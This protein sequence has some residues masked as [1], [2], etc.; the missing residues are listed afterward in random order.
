MKADR[1]NFI[2]SIQKLDADGLKSLCLSLYD[3]VGAIEAA[4]AENKRI[5][6][7]VH[8]QYAELKEK[9]DKLSKEKKELEILLQKEV[10][11][12]A[13]R[14]KS[15]FGRKTES[16][17]ALFSD[18]M[19]TEEFVDES[20]VEDLGGAG[21]HHEGHG[22]LV[23]PHKGGS[24]TK[25]NSLRQA[26]D[27]LPKKYVYDLDVD[28]YNE[29]YGEGNW[30]VDL[31]HEHILIRKIMACY[32]E[33]RIY[34][35]VVAVGRERTLCTECYENPLIDKS[36]VSDGLLSEVLTNKFHMGLPV[37]RQTEYYAMQGLPI[38][39]QTMLNWINTAVPKYLS[40][41]YDYMTKM[42][43]TFK[44]Q[45]CDETYIRVNK[46]GYRPG[47]KSIMWIQTNSQFMD[48]P[49]II[50]FSYEANRSTD[51]LRR[52]YK[53]F[54]GYLTCDAYVSYKTLEEERGGEIITT[55]CLMHLRRYFAEA[56]F[57]NDVDSM[58]DAAVMEMPETKV[59]LIIRDIYAR[60]N[61]L[62]ELDA[63]ERLTKRQETVLPLMDNLYAYIHE[64]GD[65]TDGLSY[66][67][68]KAVTY[69]INQEEHVRRFLKDGNIPCD[70]GNVERI[71]RS[72][73]VGRANWMFADTVKGADVYAI[74]YS[75]VLTA[76]AN[77]ANVQK[78]LKYL[79]EKLPPKRGVVDEQF[80]ATMMP[81]SEE[82]RKYEFDTAMA[83]LELSE[84]LFPP[85][86]KPRVSMVRRANADSAS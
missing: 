84:R 74:M 27:R 23:P 71:I 6:T 48:E 5:Y 9:Y 29:L 56:F 63:E 68:Q 31:W 32:Y 13:L 78:Y 59:L 14:N 26:A 40:V 66:R 61:K 33:E 8:I 38:S 72:Y 35:P 24:R 37:N 47:H 64:L 85:P 57:L 2:N 11:K 49:Q 44:Y 22:H 4:D 42:L 58:D 86:D 79:L 45:Q 18:P 15:T 51:H 70:N 17:L 62:K 46:D 36:L 19:E 60:E 20:E 1:E 81:W 3:R 28:K 16:T 82:Y 77:G 41:V 25:K 83:D 55:G 76:K 34:T 10:E 30:T 7:Q 69:A 54:V 53:E 73:S 67:M 65:A 50:I 75:I 39:K 21:T 80:M 52:F 43:I 12:N